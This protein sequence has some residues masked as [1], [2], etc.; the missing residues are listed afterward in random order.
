MEYKQENIF[1]HL[2]VLFCAAFM[3]VA[4][5]KGQSEMR[6]VYA[7]PDIVYSGGSLIVMTNKS[8]DKYK[9]VSFY[10]GST[11]VDSRRIGKFKHSISVPK[12]KKGRSKISVSYD[13][14][15]DTL[16]VPKQILNNKRQKNLTEFRIVE[17]D[18]FANYSLY[19]EGKNYGGFVYGDEYGVLEINQ[20]GKI[21]ISELSFGAT[22]SSLLSFPNMDDPEETNFNAVDYNFDGIS[23]VFIEGERENGD[24]IISFFVRSGKSSGF[25]KKSLE[26]K[27]DATDTDYI[28]S[29]DIDMDRKIE[30]LFVGYKTISVIEIVDP[31][32][33]E[34]DYK[35]Q[36]TK[37]IED[38][39]NLAYGIKR[40]K[41]GYINK[42]KYRDLLVVGDRQNEYSGEDENFANIYSYEE[43]GFEKIAETDR[44][45]PKSCIAIGDINGDKYGE[46]FAGT[47]N[48]IYNTIYNISDTKSKNIRFD[49]FRESSRFMGEL[50]DTC[51]D[52]SL[53][54]LQNNGDLEIKINNEVYD[55]NQIML[56]R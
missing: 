55:V 43:G 42:D 18:Y 22:A 1:I 36:S 31:E 38:I 32:N 20:E 56:D 52:V 25:S 15:G 50:P 6:L 5:C 45:I 11:E 44:I 49:V 29:M 3:S 2:V 28:R 51:R 34:V 14:G 10:I 48:R 8:S 39:D 4:G 40:V 53:F 41:M 27:W 9:N 17:D 16:S 33:E 24:Y 13:T 7:K 23:D 19:K 35:V 21:S 47:Y 37:K 30:I 12:N 26:V 46:I 54:D